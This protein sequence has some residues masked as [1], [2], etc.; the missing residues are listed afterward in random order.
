MPPILF[1]L[2]YN[3]RSTILMPTVT[4]NISLQLEAF[5][6]RFVVTCSQRFLFI[7]LLFYSLLVKWVAAFEDPTSQTLS[8]V[9]K[10][11]TLKTQIKNH[12]QFPSI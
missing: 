1:M 12:I 11:E 7:H 8:Q 5:N 10:H 4:V 9:I 3:I 6:I 2:A